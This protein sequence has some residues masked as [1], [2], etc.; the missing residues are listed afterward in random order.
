MEIQT[1]FDLLINQGAIYD[2]LGGESFIG[3]IA[4]RDGKIVGIGD[5]TGEAKQTIDAEGKIVTPAW[6]DIPHPL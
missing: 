2:G 1:V 6:I 4:I 3:N 5:V